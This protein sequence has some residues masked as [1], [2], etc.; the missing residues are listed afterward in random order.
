ML[1]TTVTLVLMTSVLVVLGDC[2]V[3]WVRA[4]GSRLPRPRRRTA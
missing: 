4:A 3:K 2:V 1:N